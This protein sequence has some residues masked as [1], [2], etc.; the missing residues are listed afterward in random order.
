MRRLCPW[1]VVAIVSIAF[2]CAKEP[3]T[4]GDRKKPEPPKDNAG[5]IANADQI[6]LYE[7]LPHPL[8]EKG[9][10]TQEK[11]KKTVALH[12]FDFYEKP[13]AP[14]EADA[15]KLMAL[16]TTPG[17]FPEFSGPKKCGGFHPDWAVEWKVGD[18]T[19][20]ALLCFGCHEAKI[21]GLQEDV[22]TDIGVEAYRQLKDLLNAY[23]ANRPAP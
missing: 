21:F 4:T 1:F 17:T 3:G 18:D 2:G 22:Y 6:V 15:K 10:F 16:F 19:Y 23:R 5:W 8:E 7:G 20:R 9:A 12:G 13:I 14:Q 11:A